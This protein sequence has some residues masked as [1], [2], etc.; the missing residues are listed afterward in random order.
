MASFMRQF[1]R[2]IDQVHKAEAER[3]RGMKSSGYT[4]YRD[5][6]VE[7]AMSDDST[8]LRNAESDGNSGE[9]Q[10]EP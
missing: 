8:G 7:E 5:M 9:G 10:R 4:T 1:E 6:R 2:A 3:V